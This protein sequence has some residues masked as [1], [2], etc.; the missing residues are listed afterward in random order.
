MTFF[1]PFAA[2][3]VNGPPPWHHGGHFDRPFHDDSGYAS[4]DSDSVPLSSLDPDSFYEGTDQYPPW[5]RRH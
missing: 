2:P 4:E 1:T 3:Y 5:T